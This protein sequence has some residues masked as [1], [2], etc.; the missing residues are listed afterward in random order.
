MDGLLQLIPARRETNTMA[1]IQLLIPDEDRDRFAIQARREG[2][3]LS[4]WLR[5]AADERLKHQ[6]RSGSFA[7]PAEIDA[8]F[9]AC[10]HLPGPSSEAN[11]NEH[12]S[13][14]DGSRRRGPS[15]R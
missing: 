12:L 1:R 10:D 8:F 3:T 6:Q 2:M 5:A 14:I 7:S 11:W 13:V 9:R 4:E 15:R